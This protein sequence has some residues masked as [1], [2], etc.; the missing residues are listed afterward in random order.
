MVRRIG[1]PASDRG[2]TLIELLIVIGVIGALSFLLIPSFQSVVR[3]YDVQKDGWILLADIRGY[4]EAAINEHVNY[5]FTFNLTQ[6]SYTIEQ[7]DAATDALLKTIKTVQFTTDLTDGATTTL[8][9]T[10]E[11]TPTTTVILKGNNIPD[12][13]TI[14]IYASGLAKLTQS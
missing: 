7:R 12:Q 1:A 4:R 2:M 6:N 5:R 10:G 3:G 9:P 14:S 11:A 8:K 13:I